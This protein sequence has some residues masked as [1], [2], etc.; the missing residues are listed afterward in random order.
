MK[1]K[2]YK[3]EVCGLQARTK[4]K[5]KLYLGSFHVCILFSLWTFQPE[6]IDR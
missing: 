5:D 3:L 4:L 2:Y 1:S 6:P